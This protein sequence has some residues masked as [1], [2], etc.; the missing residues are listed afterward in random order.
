MAAPENIQGEWIW[1]ESTGG[2]GGWR[3]T[4][5]T[6]GIVRKIVIDDASYKQFDNDK[7]VLSVKYDARA[8]KDSVFGTNQYLVLGKAPAMAYKI[9]GA[10]LVIYELCDDCFVHGYKRK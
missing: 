5:A 6:Q 4:P 3:L 2:L 8:K 9:T 10:T 7:L 1:V